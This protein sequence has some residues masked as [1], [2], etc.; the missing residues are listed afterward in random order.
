MFPRFIRT[1]RNRRNYTI[2]YLAGDD[3]MHLLEYLDIGLVN[4][5]LSYHL[6]KKGVLE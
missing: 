1:I 4:T 5:L 3:H 6:T 2:G